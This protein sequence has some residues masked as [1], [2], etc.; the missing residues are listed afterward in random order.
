[1]KESP[2]AVEHYFFTRIDIRANPG[3]DPEADECEMQLD[4]DIGF[5]RDADDVSRWQVTLSLSLGDKE[6]ERC[7][8][9]GSMEVVGLFR[10][11]PVTGDDEHETKARRII[12]ANAPALLFSAAREM[13]LI[14]CGRGPWPAPQWP[15]VHFRDTIPVKE[16][17]RELVKAKAGKD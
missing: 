4:T 7:P 17:E 6:S 12:G 16:K 9:Q 3:F 1:M 5:L 8:Y 2:L 14:V 15:T 13:F 11:P 10:L